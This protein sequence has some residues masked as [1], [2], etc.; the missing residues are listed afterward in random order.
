MTG[1][2]M[3]LNHQPGPE[4]MLPPTDEQLYGI[5]PEEEELPSPTHHI[6]KGPSPEPK[7]EDSECHRSQSAM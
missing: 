4:S 2:D 3:H 1:P 5:L 7:V 6:P